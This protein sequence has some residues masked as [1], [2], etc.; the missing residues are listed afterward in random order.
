MNEFCI[1]LKQ[2]EIRSS[3]DTF[4]HVLTCHGLILVIVVGDHGAIKR[5]FI[6]TI[7][8]R[9]PM[10]LQSGLVLNCNDLSFFVE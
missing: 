6:W 3:K 10:T 4:K 8:N 5:A 9:V 1:S 7:S 2:N